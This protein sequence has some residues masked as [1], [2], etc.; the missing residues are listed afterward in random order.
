MNKL[1]LLIAIFFAYG[2]FCCAG[3]R[4]YGGGNLSTLNTENSYYHASYIAGLDKTWEN[5][6]LTISFGLQY[7][8]RNS[9]M[10][11]ITMLFPMSNINGYNLD[12]LFSVR[13]IEL[14]LLCGIRIKQWRSA[15]IGIDFGPSLGISLGDNSKHT[16]SKVF[17]IKN[18][19]EIISSSKHLYY[20][21][22]DPADFF[23]AQQFSGIYINAGFTVEYRVIF[24]ELRYSH[25][26]TA[27]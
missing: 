23:R 25:G 15:N 13:Y 10:N 4:V 17:D 24:A 3:I 21:Y 6:L 27:L 18:K 16:F 5:K 19:Q 14:P 26:M 8:E 7:I 22:D 11:D 12:V 9:L 2:Q 1:Y 20:E